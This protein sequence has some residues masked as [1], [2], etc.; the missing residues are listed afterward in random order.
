MSS[1][2]RAKK[3]PAGGDLIFLLQPNR[4]GAQVINNK[5]IDYL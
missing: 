4:S 5:N 2:G 1:I 3:Q